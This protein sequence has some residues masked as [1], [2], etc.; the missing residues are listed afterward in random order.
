MVLLISVI[1]LNNLKKKLKNLSKENYDKM[2]RFGGEIIQEVLHDKDKTKQVQFY[3]IIQKLY[4][5]M[6]ENEMLALGLRPGDE[7]MKVE[8]LLAMA[9]D[10]TMTLCDDHL[11]MSNRM[12]NELFSF[13]STF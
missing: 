10:V 2:I 11:E 4:S 1:I 12:I 13:Q 6:S 8:M 9:H 5:Y 7:F 3:L